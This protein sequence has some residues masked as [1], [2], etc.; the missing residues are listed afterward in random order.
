MHDDARA[1]HLYRIAQEAVRNALRHARPTRIG[2]SLSEENGVRKLLVED[3]GIGLP[4]NG[5]VNHGLG[6]RIMAHRAAMIGGTFS[7]EPGPTGGTLV[8]CCF[9]DAAAPKP[10]GSPPPSL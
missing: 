6:L 10:K 8:T 1:T 5:P 3:D 9:K 2:I 4:E 7:I